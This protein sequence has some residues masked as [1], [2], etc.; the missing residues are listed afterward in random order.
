MPYNATWI[1][2]WMRPLKKP[3]PS[4]RTRR[5]PMVNLDSNPK[6][7]QRKRRIPMANLHSKTK[8]LNKRRATR[9]RR[10]S[11]SKNWSK[12]FGKA[13]GTKI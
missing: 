6:L 9:I 13:L 2:P 8:S 5:I 10:L 1:E 12:E 4:Q 7:S 11:A 3:K